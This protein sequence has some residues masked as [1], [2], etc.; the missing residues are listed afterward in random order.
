MSTGFDKGPIRKSGR[1]SSEAEILKKIEQ[2]HSEAAELRRQADSMDTLG[3]QL[4]GKPES[5]LVLREYRDKAKQLR[6]QATRKI[7]VRCKFLAD[8]LSVF[9]TNIL[10]GIGTD[11][12]VPKV[13]SDR[14]LL[15]GESTK[16]QQ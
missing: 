14:F 12:S 3:D 1:Y 4:R 2:A 8:K 16:K 11:N 5:S 15:R 7:E 6:L 13:G 9:R 10:P